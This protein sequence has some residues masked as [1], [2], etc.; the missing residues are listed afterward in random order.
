MDVC[1]I[2]AKE[3]STGDV[4]HMRQQMIEQ[5]SKNLLGRKNFQKKIINI[6]S[7]LFI[8]GKGTF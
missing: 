5:T 1:F 3:N 2:R 4:A 7:C 8:T 6:N